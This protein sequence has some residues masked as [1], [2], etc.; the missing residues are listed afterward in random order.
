MAMTD[1]TIIRRSM[2]SRMF[3]T[4]TTILTVA[5]AVALMLVLLG[6][7]KAAR[8]SFQRG[9]GNTHLIISAEPD[10]MSVVLNTIFYSRLPQQFLMY[11]RFERIVSGIPIKDD[12]G[13][14]RSGY[15][16]PM[17]QGDSYKGFPVL[18]TTPEFL[19]QFE[20]QVGQPWRFTQGAPFSGDKQVVVGAAA[21]RQTGLKLG[22]KIVLT[23]GIG[24]SRGGAPAHEHDEFKFDVVG[25]LAPSGTAHD[26]ALMVSLQSSWLV[27]AQDRLEKEH[28]AGEHHDHDADHAHEHIAEPDDLIASDKK[29][30]A[31]LIRLATAPGSAAPAALQQVAFSLKREPGLTIAQPAF[32]ITKLFGIVSNIDQVLLAMAAVVM[33]SSGIAIMLALYNSM[34]QR[35]RQIAVLRVLGC[36]RPRIF[37][38]VLTE[39]ALVGAIG[40]FVGVLIAAGGQ[41]IVATVMKQRL[42]LVIEPALAMELVLGILVATVLLASIAGLVPAVMA[43][44]TAVV[45]NL[46]PAA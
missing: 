4:V 5:V 42:G 41:S 30:T 46:K 24:D 40:A 43:Y 45:K 13:K 32:E 36:S 35:R 2:S 20:P 16:I 28:G 6:M 11:D 8:E 23:H 33:V 15:A 14:L 34:E 38:L 25:V 31:A 21:A 44:R 37:S 18:A 27:H 3:S 26:R 7:R 12:S 29:I 17:A 39:S 22:D 1:F 9:S 19:T 10:P